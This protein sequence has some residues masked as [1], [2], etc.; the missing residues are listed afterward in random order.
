MTK[1]PAVLD[2]IADRVLAYKPKAQNP[3]QKKRKRKAKKHEKQKEA[4]A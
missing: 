4:R 3:K 2:R 1:T